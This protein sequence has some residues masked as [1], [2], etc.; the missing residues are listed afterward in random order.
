MSRVRV[1]PN[2]P[3]YGLIL[4]DPAKSLFY[5]NSY[6][7]RLLR[8]LNE[9]FYRYSNLPANDGGAELGVTS[10]TGNYTAIAADSLIV[11]TLSTNAT[12]T[13][14]A[15]N[16]RGTASTW[17]LVVVRADATANVLTVQRSGSDTLDAG[18][19]TTIAASSSKAFMSNG[20]TAIYTVT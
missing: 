6:F 17:R 1:D 8:R 7:E 5:P 3:D 13:L 16:A 18:T 14:P 15:A 2:L 12:L 9:L 10:K 20:S 19:S 4:N 11:Y